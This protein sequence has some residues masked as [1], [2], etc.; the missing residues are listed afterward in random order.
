MDTDG[1][2]DARGTHADHVPRPA[3]PPPP[4]GAP[5][6]PADPPVAPPRGA[7]GARTA[8]PPPPAHAPATGPSTDRWL[9][10]ARP[11]AGA[12]V[13]RYGHVA[14]PDEGPDPARV[15]A[16]RL[17]ASITLLI[18]L[19]VWALLASGAVP[20]SHIPLVFLTPADWWA[21]GK[22]RVDYVP[23]VAYDIYS[24][25]NSVLGLLLAVW[26][27]RLGA[28]GETLR[29]LSGPRWPRV[30]TLVSLAGA[31]LC[32]WLVWTGRVPLLN[33]VF[34]LVPLTWLQG[35]GDRYA[36][37]GVTYTLYALVL[38]PVVLPFARWGGWL[39]S[40]RAF[41]T[42]PADAP[43]R[44]TAQ[45]E[46]P[47]PA[48]W[49]ELRSAGHTEAAD[50]LADEVRA[51]RMSDVDCVR[52]RRAWYASQASP[53]RRAA[54]ADAVARTGAA[55]CAHPSGARDLPVRTATHDLLTGQLR[56]GTYADDARNPYGS[57]GAGAA[58][59]PGLLGTS[60]LAVGP[61][62]S[63][64]TR[65]LVRPVAEA[66]GLQALTGQAALVVVCAAGA[67]LGSDDA[68]D[69]VIKVGDPASGHDLDLYGGAKDADE[70]AALL[71]EGLAGD[72]PDM[73]RRRAATAL[74]QLL[75][76]FH[77]AYG[78]FPGVAE[79]REL[80]DGVPER[81][82]GL[83]AA[84]EAGAHEVMLRELSA[85][86]RQSGTPGD[87]GLTLADRIAL[88]DRPAFSSFFDTTGTTSPFSLR[89]LEHPVRVRVDLPERGHTEASRLLAR[90]L[91]AQFEAAATAR[92]DRS[93]FACLV[94]DD[95]TW[96][97]TAETVRGL[98]GLR[99]A[100]AGV[101]LTLRT[102]ADVPE[103]LRAALL[104]AVGCRMTFSGVTTWDSQYFAEA[105][106]TT[107]VET[108][109][110]TERA[111]FADQPLTR[112]MH[113][114][115]KV[116]TGKEVVRNAVTVRE[117]ERQRWSASDLAHGVPAGHAVLS[118][119][120]VRGELTPPLLVDLRS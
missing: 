116:V 62:G 106:G 78:R 81:L 100:N 67:P 24:L 87:P 50:R 8:P 11:E 113:A 114:L 74:A 95:A 31:A 56:I 103:E 72:L 66:L 35:G 84:L 28:W 3:G 12:G 33:I 44:E 60:L 30:R 18:W 9:R 82:A 13:W 5:A 58:L 115:R 120:G 14:R 55:A 17:G 25:Y 27:A 99:S 107:W 40:V 92:A 119:T 94:L 10:V 102:L 22:L 39:A 101:V 77:A 64:K 65:R 83:R 111:V 109:D 51:G 88:L 73:G 38:L 4:A 110:V 49:P 89:A 16:L 52:I 86:E 36:A 21:F 97:L 69:V 63:G 75:G 23:P 19:V 47:S 54:F 20:Y 7:P 29:A 43:V 48:E 85:R 6:R 57:R 76:P 45:P 91:L 68:Y 53:T 90:L 70:A 96:T 98:Q 112:A 93:L 37:A 61:S 71:A 42:P 118:L 79:L 108:R 15:R 34:S 59:E 117:V 41:F 1:T 46:G 26:A 105:W 2:Y 104:G 80:L 32:A